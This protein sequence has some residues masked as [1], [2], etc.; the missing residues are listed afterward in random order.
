MKIMSKWT[1]FWVRKRRLIHCRKCRA[2]ITPRFE[3]VVVYHEEEPPMFYYYQCPVC[4]GQ[5][6]G[7]I[8]TEICIR[9]AQKLGYESA[10]D[11]LRKQMERR[12]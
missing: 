6:T 1:E 3:K 11:I 9:A 2:V 7:L 12:I 4:G 10:L 5:L 8:E